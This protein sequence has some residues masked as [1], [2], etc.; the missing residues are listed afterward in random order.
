MTRLIYPNGIAKLQRK[1]FGMW[2]TIAEQGTAGLSDKR[3]VWLLYQ[4]IKNA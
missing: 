3:I 4:Q 2:W 1:R